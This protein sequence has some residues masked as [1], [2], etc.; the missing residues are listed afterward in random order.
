MG[1]NSQFLH[2]YEIKFPEID[3]DFAYLSGKSFKVDLPERLKRVADKLGFN[4]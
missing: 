1:L 4:L 2:S 3:G